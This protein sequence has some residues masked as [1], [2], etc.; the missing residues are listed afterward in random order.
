MPASPASSALPDPGSGRAAA[1]DPVWALHEFLGSLTSCSPATVRAYQSDLNGFITWAT[2]AGVAIPGRVTRRQLRGYLAHLTTLGR[3]PR[4]IGRRLSSLRRYFGWLGRTGRI[5]T[6]PSLGLG[7]P[8]G[9]G[10]LPRV[11]RDDELEIL[12]DRPTEAAISGGE[13][14]QGRDDLILELL[15]GSGLRVAELCSL[16]VAD[17]RDTVE[18]SN[19][20]LITVWG[21]G[22]KQRR[23]PLNDT[24]Q[25]ALRRWLRLRDELVTDSTPAGALF[26]NQRGKRMTP[27]DVRRVVERRAPAPTHP[28]ALR[29]TFATHLLDGGADLRTVQELLGHSSLGTTQFYTHVSRERLQAVHRSTHPRG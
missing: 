22:A 14:Q 19:L 11:L 13:T 20:G 7:A 24:T 17:V 16:D 5:D 2:E 26:L 8:K 10:R 23:V 3:A 15:Y 27:R 29:H 28:H 9:E 1:Q 6:D 12:L 21:K 4:T 25:S 18:A